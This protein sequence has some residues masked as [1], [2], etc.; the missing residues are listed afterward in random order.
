MRVWVASWRGRWFSGPGVLEHVQAGGDQVGEA[1]L[2]EAGEHPI[3]HGL[4]RDAQARADQRR[5]R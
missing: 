4:E 2:V 5:W 1:A 3:A